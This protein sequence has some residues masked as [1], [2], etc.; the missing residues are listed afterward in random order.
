M[1][2]ARGMGLDRDSPRRQSKTSDGD[3][4][5]LSSKARSRYQMNKEKDTEKER[6]WEDWKLLMWWD[7]MFYDLCVSITFPACPYIVGHLSDLLKTH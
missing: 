6:L 1:N 7:I 2:A 3:A 4:S 5:A